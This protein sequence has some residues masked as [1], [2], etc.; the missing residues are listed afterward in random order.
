MSIRRGHP[1]QETVVPVVVMK[2]WRAAAVGLLF[3]AALLALA[4]LWCRAEWL[5]AARERNAQR[6][7]T[8][9]AEVSANY[10]FR[11]YYT[12]EKSRPGASERDV[13]REMLA[14]HRELAQKA[15][16]VPGK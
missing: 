5:R 14:R 4:A 8:Y 7:L 9:A 6:D 10:W 11:K 3:A 15:G 13:V 16:N 2:R 12:R 1:A